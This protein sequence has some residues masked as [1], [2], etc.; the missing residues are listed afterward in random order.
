MNTNLYDCS[1]STVDKTQFSVT[2]TDEEGEDITDE[3]EA[4]VE[5]PPGVPCPE[6]C[7]Y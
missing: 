2:I 5:M 3:F 4:E 6:G 1:N 7:P